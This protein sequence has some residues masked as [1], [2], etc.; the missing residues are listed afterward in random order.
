MLLF[1]LSAILGVLPAYDASL[2][3]SALLAILGSIG[4]YFAIAY[5]ARSATAIRVLSILGLLV[6]VTFALYFSTQ[7]GHL[8]Y[9]KGNIIARLGELTTLLP[10]LGGFTPQPNAAATFLEVAAPLGIALAASSRKPAA[11]VVLAIGALIVLYAI[12]LAASRGSWLALGVTAGLAIALTILAQLPRQT[13]RMLVGIGIA[14]AFFG[15]IAVVALGPDRLPFLSSTFSRASDRGRL[16]LNSLYL[17]GD[18]AFTGAGLGDTFAM[19]YSRYSLLIQVPFLTYAHNLPLSVWLNQG[20]LGLIAFGGLVVAFYVYVFRVNRAAQPSAL[21][22]GAWLGVTATLLHGLTDAPQYADSRW[23]MPMLFVWIGLTVASGRLALLA[24][25]TAY[26]PRFFFVRRAVLVVAVPI[27]LLAIVF[28]RPLLAAWH[29]NLGAIDETRGELAPGLDQSQR[30]ELYSSAEAAYRN[31]LGVD[32]TWPNVNRRLGN[33][34]VKLDRF[35]EAAPPLELAAARETTNPAAI[36]G[37][38]LAYVWVGRTEDAART[39]LRLDDPVEMANELYTWGNY[40]REQDQLLLAAYALETAQALYPDSTN[41]DV[42]LLIADAYRA[43]GQVD[44]ARAWYN[45][46]LATEPDNQRAR[47]ALAEIEH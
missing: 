9:E 11:K 28:H 7:Y 17:A 3:S 32:P 47:D 1:G 33:L 10:D 45:R 15:L 35:D 20:L 46:V 36:K 39:F 19:V 2:S 21:F 43:A 13:A 5:G 42:W 30:D 26:E 24:T 40:R 22:H 41:L 8:G 37:L 38:G 14:A 44:A 34:L 25:P 27:V 12:F 31:A 18:Y 23:V 16:F 4:L 6:A 29:T